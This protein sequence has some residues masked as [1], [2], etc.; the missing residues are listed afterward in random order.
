MKTAPQ[1]LEYYT[2]I[3]WNE[4]HSFW[5]VIK[6]DILKAMRHYARVKNEKSKLNFAW[7]FCGRDV[8]VDWTPQEAKLFEDYMYA[9][10]Q[11]AMQTQTIMTDIK[12]EELFP[13][14]RSLFSRLF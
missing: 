12:I 7:T 13:K 4:V 10:Q 3:D 11:R 2:E 5:W 6:E 8:F 14:K 9:Q 1:I